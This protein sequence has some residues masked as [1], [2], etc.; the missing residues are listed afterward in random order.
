MIC[1]EVKVL[2]ALKFKPMLGRDL[3]LII[4]FSSNC[5]FLGGG[6]LEL[7]NWHF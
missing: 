6:R 3:I 5:F 4:T 7:N 1:D 2:L